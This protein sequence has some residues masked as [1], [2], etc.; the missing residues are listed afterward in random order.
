[1]TE[2]LTAVANAPQATQAA[3]IAIPRTAQNNGETRRDR[4]GRFTQGNTY[5]LPPGRSGNP[6]G[7]PR[8]L[9]LT[10]RFAKLLEVQVPLTAEGAAIRER[11]GLGKSATW[12]DAIVASMIRQAVDDYR[13]ASEI[14]DRVEGRPTQ[15]H[16]INMGRDVRIRVEYVQGDDR[17][18]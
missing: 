15:R 1:M 5:R 17:K 12:A 7:R 10:D 8:K 18:E 6:G 3:V 11:F 9:S 13:V 16:E 4:K 2:P 14:A